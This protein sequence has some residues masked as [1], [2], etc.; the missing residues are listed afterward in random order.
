LQYLVTWLQ[1]EKGLKDYESNTWH[2]GKL[3]PILKKQQ[4]ASR[5]RG[6]RLDTSSLVPLESDVPPESIVNGCIPKARSKYRFPNEAI[7]EMFL[8]HIQCLQLGRTVNLVR[9]E[10]EED[11][12]ER[13][14]Q[15]D[16][17]GEEELDH[18]GETLL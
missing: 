11:D 8:E 2:K 15:D 14:N 3:V 18:D 12:E 9:P 10:E 7:A 16:E 1:P 17:E 5:G 4:P 6:K 13:E